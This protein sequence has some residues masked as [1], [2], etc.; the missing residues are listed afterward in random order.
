MFVSSELLFIQM[1]KTGCS[2]IERLLRQI[3]D[4]RKIGKHNAAT[5]Q[6]IAASPLCLSSIRNPWAW[7]VS[8][9]TFGTQGNGVLKHRLTGRS[10]EKAVAECL[11]R[12]IL[13]P[14][15]FV[16]E[17]RRDVAAWREVYTRHDDV[18]AFRTWL[19]M[20]LDPRQA[21]FL[22]E[23][24]GEV[25]VQP[26]IGYMTHRYLSLCCRDARRLEK[27]G[28]ITSFADLARFDREQCYIHAFIRQEALEETFCEAV[29]RVRPLTEDERRMVY[30]AR[31]TNTSHRVRPVADYYDAGLI[32]LVGERDRLVV[33]KFGYDPPLSEAA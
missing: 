4:G 11:R 23:G 19:S 3:F 10:V 8:L 9:W 22:G 7:Y 33:E 30:S 13:F 31:K 12:P 21:R 20:L 26:T 16:T 32:A 18:A 15:P 6:Q 29:S 2:H 27:P 24:Y 17:W 1:Q 5:P 14:R 25:R 28:R